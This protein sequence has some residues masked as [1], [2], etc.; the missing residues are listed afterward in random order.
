M[1]AAP[2]CLF[3]SST[4]LKSV[5]KGLYGSCILTRL[6]PRWLM[7]VLLICPGPVHHLSRDNVTLYDL[8]SS[9]VSSLSAAGAVV[10]PLSRDARFLS[11]LSSLL[12]PVVPEAAICIDYLM[13]TYLIGHTCHVTQLMMLSGGSHNGLSVTCT[14]ISPALLS[15]CSGR[16]YHLDAA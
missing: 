1:G 9:C 5:I 14:P 4:Q 13:S 8:V 15:R 12:S 10:L 11:P 6:A 2:S 16:A 3:I 7:W